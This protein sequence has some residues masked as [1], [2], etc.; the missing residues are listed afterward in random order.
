M[1]QA[2]ESLLQVVKSSGTHL[3]DS[4]AIIVK[5]ITLGVSVYVVWRFFFNSKYGKFVRFALLTR[6]KLTEPAAYPIY[7]PHVKTIQNIQDQLL[8]TVPGV[9]V[10]WGPPGSGKSSYAIR[11][12]NSLLK[13][14]KIGGIIKFNA[15]SFFEKDSDGG[16]TWI[17]AAM[18]VEILNPMDNISSLIP[19][20][21]ENSSYV[22]FSLSYLLRRHQRVVLLFDQFDNL[23]THGDKEALLLFIT[24]LAED[25][26]LHNSYIVFLCIKEPSL[27]ASILNLNGRSKIRLI[28]PPRD[29]KWGEDEIAQF[30]GKPVDSKWLTMAGTPGFCADNYQKKVSNAETKAIYVEEKWREG[31][32]LLDFMH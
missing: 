17:H 9:V 14:G 29:L 26:V 19:C 16:H 30:F 25:S 12:C 21:L 11:T 32:Y 22:D 8:A 1:N 4:M 13:T 31:D 10:L 7:V 24:R 3:R 20:N 18:N 15:K 2:I 5:A 23:A 28:Q 6:Y 27:A